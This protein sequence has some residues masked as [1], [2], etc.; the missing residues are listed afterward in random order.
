MTDQVVNFTLRDFKP[1]N[2]TLYLDSFPL[3]ILWTVEGDGT[4][5][6]RRP[7]PHTERE[8]KP[9]GHTGAPRPLTNS[10]HVK[11]Q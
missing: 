1:F 5:G 10:I 8:S 9:K 7:V 6:R 4:Q 3:E 2:K 11:S